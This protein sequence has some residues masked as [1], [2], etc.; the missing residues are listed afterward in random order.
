MTARARR[1]LLVGGGHSH[2]E[3]LRRFALQPDPMAVLTFVSPEPALVYTGMLPGLVAGHYTPAQAQIPLV[4]LAL[5]AGARM[6]PGRVVNALSEAPGLLE[7][8]GGR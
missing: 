6:I 3:V 7:S 8:A 1:I 5:W 4:P 2:V